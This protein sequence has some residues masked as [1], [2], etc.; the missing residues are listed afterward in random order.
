MSTLDLR[1]SLSSIP[2]FNLLHPEE[3]DALLQNA[4]IVYF[5]KN[6]IIQSPT[7][8][9][10]YYLI[11]KGVVAERGADGGV[12]VY[13]A[14]EGFDANSLLQGRCQAE[15]I[16]EEET[17]CYKIPADSF[18]SLVRTNAQFGNYYLQST[19]QKLSS[20]SEHRATSALAM[21]IRDIECA[22]PLIVDGSLSIYEAVR[23]MDEARVMAILVRDGENYGIVTDSDLRRKVLL[24]RGNV[25][26]P[27]ASIANF[28]LIGIEEDDFLFNAV[29]LMTRHHIKR[30]VVMRGGEPVAVVNEMDI[31]GAFSNQTQFLSIKIDRAMSI[32]ELAVSARA[33]P[34]VARTLQAEGIKARYIMRLLTELNT[35]LFAKLLSLIA[36]ADMIANIALVVMGSEGRK[37]QILRTDQDNAFIIRDGYDDPRLPG[38]AEAF[39]QALESFGYPLCDGGVMV[40]N[41]YWRA[42]LKEWKERVFEMINEPTPER[43]MNFAILADMRCVAGDDELVNKLRRYI[44]EHVKLAPKF[45]SHFARPILSFETPLSIFR[46]FVL[47]KGAHQG[48]FDLKKGAIFPIV[49]GIRTLALEFEITSTNN[50]FGRIKELNNQGFFDREFAA[51]LIEALEFLFALRLRERL[52]KSEH[53]M[54]PD[55]YVAPERLSNFD[56][57]LLKEALKVAEKFKKVVVSHYRL[58]YF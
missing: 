41:S 11:V 20:L 30:L 2:P 18:L 39:V 54:A 3:L 32:E 26:D 29:L 51:S 45:L 6:A 4:D 33:I 40:S 10:A 43:L 25:D 14:H 9:L 22:K 13:G 34:A 48:E 57:D 53:G 31:L 50:T 21:R 36:P 15:F 47:E 35:K 37:E 16:A 5:P 28:R 49:H 38:V 44:T 17:I 58:D 7:T 8:E 56:R 24:A 52:W 42:S 12:I 46:T 23:A 27:I 55:N 1:S 19:A